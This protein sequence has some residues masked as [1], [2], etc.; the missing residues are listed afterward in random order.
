MSVQVRITVGNF[1]RPFPN[2]TSSVRR[3]DVAR[4]DRRAATTRAIV[5]L[6]LEG[7]NRSVGS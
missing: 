6:P 1:G 3:L 2:L 4:A 5:R 7:V